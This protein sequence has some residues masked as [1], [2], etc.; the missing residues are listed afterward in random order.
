MKL[1]RL[2][3]AALGALF[4]M[5]TTVAVQAQTVDGYWQQVQQRGVLRCGAAVGPPHVNLD[6]LTGDYSGTFVDLCREFGEQV[7]GVKVQMVTTSWDNIVA[8]LQSGRW[9]LA[10]SLNRTPKRA[11]AIEYSAPA[12]QY[13]LTAVYDKADPKIPPHPTSLS[14]IDKDG[15]TIIVD[16][17]TSADQLLS[18]NIKHATLLRLQDV[19]ATHLALSSGR[20]DVL[21]DDGDTN[22]IFVASD[23]KRWL[24]LK[25]SPALSKQG[26]AFGLPRTVSS[27][28]IAVLNIFIENKLATGEIQALGQSYINQLAGAAGK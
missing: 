12:W 5:V 14:D 1:T 22:A 20:G 3:V 6:P 8:G 24:T 21:F 10:L 9:D 23:T 16:A 18:D 15:V 2:V 28:D 26:I 27:A 11:L 7:L 25:P 19:D 4:A 17:G 13:E